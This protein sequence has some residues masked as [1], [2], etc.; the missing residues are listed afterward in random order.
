MYTPERSSGLLVHWVGVGA[1]APPSGRRLQTSASSSTAVLSMAVQ[2][3]L[4]SEGTLAIGF[5]PSDGMMIPGTA[6]IG[7]YG[8]A[9]DSV[10]RYT[11]S[12]RT[13]GGVSLMADGGGL[14]PNAT[15]SRV[16]GL[17]TLRF[18]RDI[19]SANIDGATPTS[20]IW[21][22]SNVGSKSYHG[23]QRGAFRLQ[24]DGASVAGGIGI[25]DKSYTVLAH[26][27][28]MLL[29][30]GI[31]LP[32][33]TA[34]AAGMRDKL[35]APLWYTLHRNM[36]CFGLVLAIAGVL[37]I[38]C[39]DFVVDFN[40]YSNHGNLGVIVTIIGALQPLNGFL[41]PDKKA[42]RRYAWAYLHKGS[43]WLGL[44]LAAATIFMGIKKFDETQ[45][46]TFPGAV[47]GIRATY[48]V[49]LVFTATLVV[50]GAFFGG[51]DPPPK[52][53]DGAELAKWGHGSGV[54]LDT[55]QEGAPPPPP[56]VVP[57][58]LTERM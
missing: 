17:V 56:E 1:P 23:A 48:I 53:P 39:S 43:G 19:S 51:H 58:V 14:L 30:W 55:V 36:Q 44:L 6:V 42:P 3:T 27:L 26:A 16:D 52:A 49:V 31:F 18:A 7:I 24:L 8:G 15:I 21:A 22:T 28:C 13:M 12:S 54:T 4:G 37:V 32:I 41:R 34:L 45:G 35:G 57:H 50:R 5:G 29:G 20:L 33:G 11:L 47:D 10:Q 38:T 40:Q 9:G 25:S 46:A 2:A